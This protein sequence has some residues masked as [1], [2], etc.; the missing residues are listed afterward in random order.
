MTSRLSW[1][2]QFRCMEWECCGRKWQLLLSRRYPERINFAPTC[3]CG[4]VGKTSKE[5]V[6]AT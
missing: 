6:C 4:E 1:Y 2:K 5:L 3:V